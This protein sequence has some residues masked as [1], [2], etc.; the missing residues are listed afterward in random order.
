MGTVLQDLRYGVRVLRKHP[1]F[2]A[3]ALF[4]L[5]LGIGANAAIFSIV[6]A[7]MLKPLPY[8]DADRL[9][10]LSERHE[11]IPSRFISYPNFLDW[12]ERNQVFEAMSTIR[13]WALT[14][15]GEGEP[16]GL[17]AGMVSAEYFS[18]MRVS[19]LLGRDFT[20]T[21]DKPGADPVTILSYGFWQRQ[22][23]GD[24]SIIGK[25]ITL[26]NRP[27]TVIGV[28]PPVLRRQDT[29]PLWVL[30]GQWTGQG[31]W[32]QRD[33]RVAGYVVARLKPSVTLPAARARMDAVQAELSQL[34]PW[35]NASHRITVV[36][37][38]ESVVGDARQTLLLLLGAVGF[39]LLIACA[40]V[41]NLLLAR[42]S[43]RRREFALR[44]ALG[45]SRA[46]LVRQLLTESLV[47]SVVG[48]ALGLLLAWWGVDL[49]RSASPA[50]IPRLEELA[51]DYRVL[52]Y[53]L[54]VS[55]ATGI[56]FGLAPA[57]QMSRRGLNEMLKEGGKT[58]SGDGRGRLR[59]ALVV[60]EIALA[61]VLLVGAGLLIRSFARLLNSETG[62]DA[63]NVATV[64]IS[65]PR[66]R[67]SERDDINRFHQQ[68]LERV[69]TLPG[70]SEAAISNEVPGIQSGWQN[71]IAVPGH[72]RIQP[73]GEINV[74][75]GI[76][77]AD[78]FEVMRITMLRGRT[79]NAQEM[80]QRAPVVVVDERLANRFWP[81]GDALGKRLLYDGPVPHEIIGVVRTI[82]TYGT[83]EEPRIKIYTPL[84]RAYLNV[85]TLSIRAAA[86]PQALAAAVTRE[87][88]AIDRD[89]PAPEVTTL[90]QLLAHQ[91]SARQLTTVL[92]TVFATIALLLAAIGIY[93]VMSYTVARRTHEIGVR[94]ALGA[95]G[96]DVLKLVI[97]QGIRLALIG[98]ACGLV[99]AFAATRVMAGMLYGI[100]A[101]DP[102]T[103]V[104]ISLVLA[105]VALLACYVPARRATKV[106]PMI[107]L[108]YE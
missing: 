56:L 45:A 31:N 80:E 11:Q 3:V 28:V 34:Y 71:D 90:E 12:R 46:R 60:A 67:Y 55:L 98:I 103:F 50:G 96:R 82:K 14:L 7:V 20:P 17:S 41:A 73:G 23:G 104:A 106:D 8:Q 100:S 101:T 21:E 1:A 88:H 77:S 76:V 25:T 91:V 36:T 84:N 94:M 93:G 16:Q 47:L 18:V 9:V 105:L 33:V 59:G 40:N 37:L 48:G 29:R 64:R 68:L 35:T 32:M 43:T 70:V 24:E 52:S 87:I 81:E 99:G 38:Y 6:N 102:L 65:L 22:F 63:Q 95:Q 54:L 26:D 2:T 30:I 85:A 74:D 107:A 42:A 10:M 79:F 69:S 39:V 72:P 75:W 66:T 27:F 61:L 49:F 108:R 53:T 89:L 51:L 5:A 4:A 44:A 58:M 62:F 86:D 83:G 78:Y 97:G 19:P 92:L 15:T 57:W 13:T